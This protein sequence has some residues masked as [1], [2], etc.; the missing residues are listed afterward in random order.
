MG[1]VV[2]EFR[3]GQ[4]ASCTT[5]LKGCPDAWICGPASGWLAASIEGD[6]RSLELG[7]DCRF[8]RAV[9]DGLFEA[10]SGAGAPTASHR[11]EP[12]GGALRA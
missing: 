12:A 2:V 1:G 11:H 8:A 10:L 3:L 9:L 6:V 7:G 4:I 5:R